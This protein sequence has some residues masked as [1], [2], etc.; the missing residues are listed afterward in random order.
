MG[1]AA[2]RTDLHPARRE[3]WSRQRTPGQRRQGEY[4]GEL[5][6]SDR[7]HSLRHR[8]ATETY[9]LTQHIRVVQELLGHGSPQ[10]T[11]GYAAYSRQ[12]AVEA[13]RMLD[14]VQ[15]AG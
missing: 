14:G 6:L 3:A 12:G 7:A 10:T 11:S 1:T 2:A 8:F 15:Q 9:R 13:V 4:L 5:G